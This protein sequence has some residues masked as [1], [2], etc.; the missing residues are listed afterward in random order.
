MTTRSTTLTASSASTPSIGLRAGRIALWALQIGLAL[1]FVYIGSLKLGGD[2]Q[3]V[4][5]FDAIG[6]GQWFRYLTGG[7]EVIA[8]IA[9]LVPSLALFGALALVATMVGAVI[10]HV[11]VIGGSSTSALV[12]LVLSAI[13][14]WARRDQLQALV[15][16]R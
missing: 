8:G 10:T 4:G 6:I 12:F 9:L 5:A 2:P 11:F 3:L 15:S 13:V 7:I 1:Q 16:R 14:V